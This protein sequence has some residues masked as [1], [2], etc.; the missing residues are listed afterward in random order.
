MIIIIERVE[1]RSIQAYCIQTSW[2]RSLG[3]FFCVFN[4]AVSISFL[5]TK[6]GFMF[7]WEIVADSETRRVLMRF[8]KT[9]YLKFPIVCMFLV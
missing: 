8:H 9:F 4:I 2:L 5:R 6:V 3:R 7:V 1:C